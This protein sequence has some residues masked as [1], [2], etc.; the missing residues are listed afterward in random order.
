M[1]T[2]I[3]RFYGI[4]N[5]DECIPDNTGWRPKCLEKT[6]GIIANHLFWLMLEVLCYHH[7]CYD[8]SVSVIP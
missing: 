8:Y 7:Y 2:F 6:W 3:N 4:V 1:I 5:L